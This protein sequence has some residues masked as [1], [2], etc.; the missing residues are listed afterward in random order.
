MTFEIPFGIVFV[1]DLI[2]RKEF[3]SIL[4]NGFGPSKTIDFPKKNH[5]CFMFF[6]IA[7]PGTVFRGSLCRTVIKMWLLVP[8]SIFMVFK[9]APFGPPFRPSGRKKRS[10][11]SDPRRP[12]RD[13]VFHETIVILVPFGPSV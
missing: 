11:T 7:P 2:S 4:F 10:P 9:K 13:P 3:F 5:R 1:N 12:S 8:F 6:K